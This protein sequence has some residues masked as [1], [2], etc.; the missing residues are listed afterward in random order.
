MKAPMQSSLVQ[1][2][3]APA[4]TADPIP[5]SDVGHVPKERHACRICLEGPRLT[6]IQTSWKR[7][8]SFRIFW[9]FWNAS[10]RVLLA[11]RRRTTGTPRLLCL[12]R[13]RSVY[14]WGVFTTAIWNATREGGRSQSNPR[15]SLFRRQF[16][17]LIIL[18]HFWISAKVRLDVKR[19][20]ED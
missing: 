18:Y 11:S 1:E 12:P 14:L 2:P 6:C 3:C 5:S 20:V 4:S 17:I 10:S 16:F 13:Q 9:N 8:E 7:I 15:S 19:M